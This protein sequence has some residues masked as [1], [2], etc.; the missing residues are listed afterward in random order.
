MPEGTPISS[1]VAAAFSFALTQKQ[2]KNDD[3][4]YGNKLALVV[5]TVDGDTNPTVNHKRNGDFELNILRLHSL[6]AP[7]IFT[8]GASQKEL[9]NF[10]IYQN[11]DD[12]LRAEYVQYLESH[13]KNKRF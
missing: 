3:T 12:N 11:L 1:A 8:R 13:P 4:Q 5:P 2:Q 7:I 10:S 6:K 9:L